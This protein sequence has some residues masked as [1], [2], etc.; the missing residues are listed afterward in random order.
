MKRKIIFVLL[1]LVLL[2]SSCNKFTIKTKINLDGSFE[3][4]VLCEGDSLGIYNLPLPFVFSNG[5]KIEIREKVGNE[6]S[7]ITTATKQYANADELNTEYTKGQDSAKLKISTHIEKVFRWFFTYYVYEET[8]P[9]FGIIKQAISIDSVFTPNELVLLKDIKDTKDSL[10]KQRYSEY[11]EQNIAGEFI[12]ELIIR[13]QKLNDPI[14]TRSRWEEHRISLTRSLFTKKSNQPAD[15][16]KLIDKIF[17]TS[18]TKKL[19]GAIETS[20]SNI[21]RKVEIEDKLNFSYK[22][23]IVMPG[24][25]ITSNSNKVE[26]NKLMWDCNSSPYFDVV[27]TAES[28]IVNVWAMI[29]TVIVCGALLIGLL[30]PLIHEK[31][32]DDIMSK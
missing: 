23:E 12:E 32:Q 22:N 20:F 29:L 31:E 16:T 2:F 1:L 7:F 11:Y 27:M 30:Y 17:K 19:H 3:K 18:S 26:G 8:I 5:W 14:F 9:A 13:S 6:K 21:K 10:L 24:I 25:L 15:I 28:R 4:T